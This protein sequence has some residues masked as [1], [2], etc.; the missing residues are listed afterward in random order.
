MALRILGGTPKA[1]EKGVAPKVGEKSYCI[2]DEALPHFADGLN[3][4]NDRI[5]ESFTDGTSIFSG[6]GSIDIIDTIK[7]VKNM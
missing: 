1:V 4:R 2:A 7:Q 5:A 3:D 6:T